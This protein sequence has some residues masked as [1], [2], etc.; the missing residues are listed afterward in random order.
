MNNK[1]IQNYINKKHYY[2][3]LT[4]TIRSLLK[5]LLEEAKINYQKIESRTKKVSSLE[6]KINLK[7]LSNKQ[8]KNL[9]EITDLSGI[10]I[11]V[12]F[13]DDIFKV[14][15]LIEKEFKIYKEKSLDTHLNI[16]KSP[17]EFGYQSL[18]RIVTINKSRSNLKEYK[19]F[20]NTKC[21]IQ[22]RTVLQHAWAEIEHDIGYKSEIKESDQDRIEL[23]RLLSQNA[24]LLEIADDAFVK[25]K[26]LYKNIIDQ[27][28]NKIKNNNFNL[29]FNIDSMREFL[30]YHPTIQSNTSHDLNSKN[31]QASAV[32][33]KAKNKKISN[34]KKFNLNQ[35]NN[36]TELSKKIK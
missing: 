8:Y 11:I 5:I 31:I 7:L 22:I 32:L 20:K 17:K 24:A 9:D 34:F 30:E 29:P 19:K 36:K 23:T 6:N 12:F 13:K 14:I 33:K 4:H 15:N 28:K 16:N 21:E 1:L 3:N 26:N 10:R 25:S 18:H 35:N 2:E 27:Y